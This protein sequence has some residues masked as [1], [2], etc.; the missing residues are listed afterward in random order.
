MKN[1]I[2]ICFISIS[3]ITIAQE[4]KTWKYP[5][6]IGSKEWKDMSY[7]DKI[8]K[9]Q[10]PSNF[11]TQVSTKELFSYC[12]NYPFNRDL[13]LFNNPDDG[14]KR[15]FECSTVW[16]EFVKRKDACIVFVEYYTS[17]TCDQINNLSGEEKTDRLFNLFFLEKI[18]GGTAFLDNLKTEEK[19]HLASVINSKIKEKKQYPESFLGFTYNSSLSALVKIMETDNQKSMSLQKFKEAT[20]EE[21]YIVNDIEESIITKVNEYI[22]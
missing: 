15:V 16:Q 12:I 21:C 5:I 2:F 13:L 18:I 7:S 14:F 22:Q 1:V 4:K 8:Q 9:S 17:F 19:K 20:T 6:S 10:P 3:C 11:L